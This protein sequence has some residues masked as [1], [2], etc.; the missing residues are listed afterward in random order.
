MRAYASSKDL[1]NASLVSTPA[2][3]VLAA[4]KFVDSDKALVYGKAIAASVLVA[5][6]AWT[7]SKYID[8][9]GLPIDEITAN[10]SLIVPDSSSNNIGSELAENPAG[11]IVVEGSLA[12]EYE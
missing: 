1:A 12:V 8:Y 2:R 9:R 10:E 5:A 6:L 3:E 7:I 11:L 4:R